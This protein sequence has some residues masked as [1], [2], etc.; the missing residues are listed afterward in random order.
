M[1]IIG[2]LLISIGLLLIGWFGYVELF[3]LDE[4]KSGF[5]EQRIKSGEDISVKIKEAKDRFNKVKDNLKKRKD[6]KKKIAQVDVQL[7]DLPANA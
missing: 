5:E 2:I 6:S 3:Y 4:I 7:N 1:R